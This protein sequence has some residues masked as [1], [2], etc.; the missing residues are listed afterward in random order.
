[1]STAGE[2][3]TVLVVEDNRVEREGTG[4]VLREKGYHVLLAANGAEAWNHL[5]SDRLPDLMVLD[6]M[7]PDVDGW[8]LLAQVRSDPALA[9]MPVL[10]ATGLGIANPKWAAS[11]GAAGLLRKPFDADQL[12]QEVERFR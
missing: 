9:S 3:K 8:Q 10:I 7:L 5:R 6:M 1:M 11:L 4:V 12:I 2:S